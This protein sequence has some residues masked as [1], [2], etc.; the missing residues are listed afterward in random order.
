MSAIGSSNR[1]PRRRF[2]RTAPILR[3]DA[4]PEDHR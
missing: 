3:N 4:Q 1:A 2:G